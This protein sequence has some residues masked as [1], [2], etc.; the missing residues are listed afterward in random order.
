MKILFVYCQWLLMLFVNPEHSLQ[1]TPPSRLQSIL[2]NGI[3]NPSGFGGYTD[4]KKAKEI[5]KD[6]PGY[7]GSYR[8]SSFGRVE[9]LERTISTPYFTKLFPGVMLRLNVVSGYCYVTLNN[10]TGKPKAVRVHRL[11]AQ[12]FCKNKPDSQCVNHKNG[13]K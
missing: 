2:T 11:V 4:M 8:V 6:I 10:V 13:I 3:D 9:S 12:A 1:N 7:E 5:W